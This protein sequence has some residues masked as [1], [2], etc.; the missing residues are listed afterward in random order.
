MALP[1][2]RRQGIAM[3]DPAGAAEWRGYLTRLADRFGIPLR[4]NA[5]AIG[6]SHLVE[7][8]L[9]EKTAVGLGEMSIDAA[10]SGLRRIPIVEPAILLPW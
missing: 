5:P 3:P 7:Q 9:R 4:F 10:G 8:F 6:Q 1:A 2:L